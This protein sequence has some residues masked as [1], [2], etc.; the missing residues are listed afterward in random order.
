M[1]S[2]FL[3]TY[4]HLLSILFT[5]SPHLAGFSSYEP[6]LYLDIHWFPFQSLLQPYFVLWRM[7][8]SSPVF[9]YCEDPLGVN[10][11]GTWLPLSLNTG[12]ALVAMDASQYQWALCSVWARDGQEDLHGCL[13]SGTGGKRQSLGPSHLVSHLL[14]CPITFLLVTFSLLLIQETWKGGMWLA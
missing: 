7:F 8:P 2:W 10:F 12:L 9:T 14:N 13:L 3:L 4:L 6:L 5:Q 1:W 11:H